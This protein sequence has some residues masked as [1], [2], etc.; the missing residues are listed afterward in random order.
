M[1]IQYICPTY[2][3]W[4]SALNS[5]IGSEMGKNFCA[6]SCLLPIFLTSVATACN[7]G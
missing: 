6:R 1:C 2:F 5:I 4:S 3:A 7:R